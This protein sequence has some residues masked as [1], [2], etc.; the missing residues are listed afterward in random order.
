MIDRQVGHGFGRG[1][2][3]IDRDP[4][5]AVRFA[6]EPAPREHACACRTEQNLERGIGLAGTTIGLRRACDLDSPVDIIISPQR[7]IAP[8][9]SAVAGR[10]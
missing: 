10:D 4:M 3:D 6:P 5:T 1:E 2:P 8:A 7:A 9:Q